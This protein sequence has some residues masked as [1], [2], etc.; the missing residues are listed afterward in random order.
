V[1]GGWWIVDGVE[2]QLYGSHGMGLKYLWVGAK[3]L[4]LAHGRGIGQDIALGG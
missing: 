4:E 3:V 1:I 2:H